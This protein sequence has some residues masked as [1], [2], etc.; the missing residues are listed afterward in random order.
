M[1]RIVMSHLVDD[2]CRG[3]CR[4]LF[5]QLLKLQKVFDLTFDR[6]GIEIPRWAKSGYQL[7]S[8]DLAVFAVAFNR[9]LVTFE[10]S[11]FEE[12]KSLVDG[13][14]ILRQVVVSRG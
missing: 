11:I 4:A 12:G 8:S 13:H 9:S 3:Y 1:G 7:H 10:P 2:R 6:L 5:F 14:R